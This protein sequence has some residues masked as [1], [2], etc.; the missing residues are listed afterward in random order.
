MLGITLVGGRACAQPSGPRSLANAGAVL[1]RGASRA[2]LLEGARLPVCPNDI[3][4][5]PKGSAPNFARARS[6]H[7]TCRPGCS[8][9][10]RFY[11]V[12]MGSDIHAAAFRM[13][14]MQLAH[15]SEH[16]QCRTNTGSGDL[17][18]KLSGK[19]L[20]G[21]CSVRAEMIH[22]AATTTPAVDATG[23]PEEPR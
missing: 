14:S 15:R 9:Q 1:P 10:A 20:P 2:L 12:T 18:G 8:R 7:G 3:L 4:Q 16:P 13:R 23:P 22:S 6:R 17:V 21:G 11:R 5:R 19:L